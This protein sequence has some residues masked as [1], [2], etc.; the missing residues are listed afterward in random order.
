MKITVIGGGPAGLYFGI[1]L[2]KQFGNAQIDVFER[3]G[4]NDTFGWGVVFSGRTLKE[5][6]ENDLPSYE[7]ILEQFETWENVDVVHRGEKI[8]IRGN[9]FN[10]ISRL[11]M[12]QIMQ[13]RAEELGVLIHYHTEVQDLV[14]YRSSDLVLIA[15]GVNS[16]LRKLLA[17]HFQPT[18]SVRTNKYI[19]YGTEKLFHGLTL[20]FRENEHG[21]FAAHSYKFSKTHST[22]VV[23]CDEGTWRRAGLDTMSEEQY[24][25]YIE[26][27]FEHDL[28]GYPLLSNRS[29]WINFQLIKCQ[30]WVHENMVIVGDA[31][32]TAHFS[33]GSGTKLALEDV[34]ALAEE[35]KTESNIANALA[36]YERVRRPV[37]EDLQ[38]AAHQSL[39]LFENLGDVIDLSPLEMAYRMMTRSGRI[40]DERLRRRDP[41]FMQRLAEER[42]TPQNVW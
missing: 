35:I 22:F 3:N 17:E 1:L 14:P 29:V 4:P 16:F 36:N 32:H 5:L 30:H 38:A 34:I 8:T 15:D 9:H 11:T 26:R 41:E 25:H 10:G 42:S 13:K 39:L 2:K 19:W 27:V 40:D 7:R 31:A 28:D 23:E 12:L 37:V 20:T 24:R 21:I 18:I 6:E 33:I